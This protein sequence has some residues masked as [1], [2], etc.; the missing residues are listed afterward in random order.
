MK[1]VR[2]VLGD[3]PSE[4]LGFTYPHEHLWAIPPMS[5]KDRDL[6][7]S[8][9][10]GSLYELCQ[11]KKIGGNTLVDASTLDYGRDGKILKSLSIEAQVN[12]IGVSGF[13]KHIYYPRWV[14]VTDID[15]IAHR[16]ISDITRGM[17]FS[18]AKAGILKGGTWYNYIHPLE[19]KTTQAIVHAFKETNAPIWMHTE[20]GTM[21]MEIL[22]LFAKENIPADSICL[23]HIDRNADPY[24]HL[25]LLERGVFL[26]F[27]GPAKVKY[28]PDSTRI[29][30]INNIINH[31]FEDRLL[32]SGDMG[33]QSY[34]SGYG[35]GPGF[36]FIKTKF[37][38]RML[39]EG[40]C[41]T[42]ID[43][44]FTDNPANW[45]ARF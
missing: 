25:K 11:F 7:L 30:L 2:T 12:V 29:D 8:D 3:I 45:L 24:Y 43:K 27:D 41:G 19:Q 1:N 17:D 44:I 13:N 32:I 40:I 21:G 33:R 14:E 10:E 6:E 37:I 20:V 15:F 16:L 23:G 4:T 5:Q 36:S 39:D 38:P 26:Q 18:D 35:G 31:G 9:Y 22:D 34:L 28:Y 42:V